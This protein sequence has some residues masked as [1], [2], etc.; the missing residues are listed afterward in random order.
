MA[1]FGA[2]VDGDGVVTDFIKLQF[3]MLRKNSWRERERDLKVGYIYIYSAPNPPPPLYSVC[4]LF[5]IL[6]V[7]VH[8]A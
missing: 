4:L 3:L 1:S 8:L 7:T 6:T 5:Y 2:L